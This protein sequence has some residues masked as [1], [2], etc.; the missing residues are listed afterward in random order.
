MTI[1]IDEWT[2]CYPSN[3]KGVIVPE[4]MTHPAKFSSRLIQRIYKHLWDEGW[5]KLGDNVLDPFGGVALGAMNAMLYR[6]NWYGIE[7]EEKFWKLGNADIEK[8]RKDFKSWPALGDAQLLHGDS[9]K[10]LDVLKASGVSVALS[11]PP[12]ETGGHHKHQVDSYNKNGGGQFTK[13]NSGYGAG[14]NMGMDAALS[15]PPHA[16]CGARDMG[17]QQRG[18]AK[19]LMDQKGDHYNRDNPDNLGNVNADDFWLAARQI[20]EQVYI[21]LR[22][23]GHAVWVVKDYVKNKERLP[24]CDQ[25]RQLCEAVGFVTLHEHHALLVRNKRTQIDLEG[26]HHTTQSESKSFFR[27]LAEKKGSPRIDYEVVLCMVK[28]DGPKS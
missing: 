25:W 19:H 23:G 1:E 6:L 5:V 7:L 2:G 26:N 22:P 20:V 17:G 9:R 11:S 4:A 12:Y 14:D 8:W 18:G 21:A 27:R 15:S 3:W 24:F 10:L 13:D 28:G 16:D